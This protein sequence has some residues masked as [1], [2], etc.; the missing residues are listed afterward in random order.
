MTDK[1]LISQAFEALDELI[2]RWEVEGI[3]PF[4]LQSPR[5]SP[6]ISARD[7]LLSALNN[8]KFPNRI[9]LAEAKRIAIANHER[10]EKLM[11][12]EVDRDARGKAVWEDEEE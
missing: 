11:A 4:K 2:K 1:E 10:V 5:F 6:L 12:E 9:S 3:L 8:E 7:H